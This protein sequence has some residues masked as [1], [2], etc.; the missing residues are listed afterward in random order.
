MTLVDDGDLIR[1]LGFVAL[2]AA[3]L[4]GAVDEC[5]HVIAANDSDCKCR[6]LHRWGTSRKLQYLQKQ[7]RKL[8]PLPSELAN[9]PNTL[10]AISDLFEER[11]LVVHGRI[12]SIPSVGDVRISGRLGIPETPVRSAELYVLANDLF[13]ARIPLQHASMFSL[14]RAYRGFCSEKLT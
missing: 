12:Y 11:N 4:E 8:E 2:Y 13:A 6:D 5:L 3:Y 1:G 9:F 7:L 14:N 10:Q